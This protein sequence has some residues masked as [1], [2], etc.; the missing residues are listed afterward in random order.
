MNIFILDR[1]PILAARWQHDRHVVSMILKSAQM[2]SI[3]THQGI[4]A[5]KFHPLAQAYAQVS[6]TAT[7]DTSLY[8]TDRQP[9]SVMA[10]WVYDDSPMSFGWLSVHLCELLNE[11]RRRFNKAHKCDRFAYLFGAMTVRMV[12][13]EDS[14]VEGLYG[15]NREVTESL[16]HWA[17]NI[18]S[19]PFCGPESY[20]PGT[21]NIHKV[22]ESYRAYYIGEKLDGNRWSQHDSMV[23]PEWLLSRDPALHLRTTPVSAPRPRRVAPPQTFD[24]TIYSDAKRVRTPSF[25]LNR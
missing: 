24:S 23:L 15:R 3:A 9:D 18:G 12:K 1:N 16:V 6:R 22:V 19:A 17:S 8:S 21:L 2:L 11:Y 10:E 7:I 4:E 14:R 20:A 13:S 5:G 25:L